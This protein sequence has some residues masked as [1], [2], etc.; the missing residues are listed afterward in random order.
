MNPLQRAVQD[1]DTVPDGKTESKAQLFR[2]GHAGI[3]TTD[4]NA[5]QEKESTVKS[6]FKKPVHPGI[7]L[8]GSF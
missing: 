3:L 2:D 7:P 8:E 6:S 4:F 5:K 1:Y